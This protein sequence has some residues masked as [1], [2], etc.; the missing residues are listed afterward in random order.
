[1]NMQRQFVKCPKHGSTRQ[2]YCLPCPHVMDQTAPVAA[3]LTNPVVRGVQVSHT[4]LLCA[5]CSVDD[6]AAFLP[7][8][9]RCFNAR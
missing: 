6:C 4:V 8:C 5:A 9:E 1:M 2:D 3:A 7:L